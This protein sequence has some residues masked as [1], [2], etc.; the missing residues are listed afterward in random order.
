MIFRG[1]ERNER[2]PVPVIVPTRAPLLMRPLEPRILL[3]AAGG[4]TALATVNEAAHSTLAEVYVNADVTE[5]TGENAIW[6]RAIQTLEH[7]P[8]YI[9]EFADI[10]DE[11]PSEIAF[12]ASDVPDID[13]L[14]DSLSSNVEIVVL[15]GGS[16]GMSQIADVLRYRTNLD[17]VHIFSHGS[18][19][20]LALGGV[21]VN[22]ETMTSVY[23]AD[24]NT[25]GSSLVAEGDILIYG[26]D[27]A[28]G[29]IGREAVTKFAQ[30]TGA[31]IA[32]SNDPTG[33][34]SLGGDWK[35]ERSTGAIE[36]NS[37]DA[38]EGWMGTLA[39]ETLVAHE[40]PFSQIDHDEAIGSNRVIGQSFTYDSGSATYEVD[41]IDLVM[42]R[43]GGPPWQDITV[44]IRDTFTGTDIVRGTLNATALSGSYEW[45][46][47]TLDSPAVLNSNQSY[48]FVAYTNHPSQTID[49]G[50]EHD[51]G[52][53]GGTVI[54]PDGTPKPTDD[55]LFRLINTNANTDP[56]ITSDGGT[57]VSPIDVNENQTF[58]ATVTA[59]DPDLPADTLTYY[60]DGGF[61]A[62]QFII[63]PNSGV[64]SF[65]AP[66][67]FENPTDF[68]PNNV[69]TLTVGVSDG[70]GGSDTE[71]YVVRVNDVNDAPIAAADPFTVGEDGSV[72]VDVL[73]N[74][75]DDEGDPLTITH[76]DA[77]AVTDGG[78]A[79]PV[80]NGMVQLVAGEL[81]FTPA[82]NYNGPATFTYTVSD[83]NG[84]TGTAT[85]SGTVTP[86]NDAPMAVDNAY[87]TN[88]DTG[89]TGNAIT[90][91]TGLGV[92]SDIEGDALTLDVTSVG[93]FATAQGGS[94]NLIANGS[95]TYT[96]PFGFNGTDSFS[97]T[98]TDGALTD[99]A[100]LT[101]NVTSVNDAPVATG[102]VRERRRRT[103]LIRLPLPTLPSA[104]QRAMPCNR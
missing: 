58:V 6:A 34:A 29:E 31:D 69:Y 10:P 30:L 85:V 88:E 33:H 79:V 47:I 63:D 74:D 15:D 80:A 20:A 82:S 56:T 21:E 91:D 11:Q 86:A 70:S 52:Y 54:E 89:V 32:A 72:S 16:D 95:F 39:P 101:F 5:P 103:P 2:T 49:V 35:L 25:I 50:T 38:G 75:S 28:S 78:F 12:I 92:D 24:L 64:L 55:M 18:S 81:I 22:A 67:D 45:S 41:Q 73:A 66:P 43:L 51:V 3:D 17:A 96:P 36:V 42:R 48:V 60:I 1:L 9:P 14:L 65:I 8:P 76:V 93:T 26:C 44:A 53:P 4:E 59:T 87:T 23:E 27:F 97:Y 62:A 98:I 84:G 57:L 71:S 19:G 90:D 77:Q 61:D 100:T 68:L 104:T 7:T 40:A 37:L 46:S 13:T 83:G 94:I 102:G 99:T